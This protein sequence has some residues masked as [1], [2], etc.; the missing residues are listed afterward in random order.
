MKDA[1]NKFIV[2][3]TLLLLLVFPLR[4][5]VFLMDDEF[6]SNIRVGESQ[7]VVPAPYQGGDLDQYLPLGDGLILL[8]SFGGAY[9][10]KKG[11]KRKKAD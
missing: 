10:L 11:R 7:F 4:A 1:K 5:Q 9:L 3:A 8:T 2:L 6:E